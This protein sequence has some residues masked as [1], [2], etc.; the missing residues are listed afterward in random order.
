MAFELLSEP[1]RRYVKDKRWE[2]LRPIQAAAIEKIMKSDSN[3]ILASRTA[4]GKTEA[5]FLPILSK[6]SPRSESVQVLYIS[7]LIALIND[8]FIR[9]EDLCSY[10]DIKVTKWHGEAN[11]TAKEHLI[12]EPNGVVLITPESLEAMLVNKSQY[13]SIL[14]NDLKYIVID[15]IHSFIG[16]DRG[17][18]LKSILHRIQKS[19]KVTPAIVGLSATLGDFEEA[20]RM[21]GRPDATVVLRDRTAKSM[22]TSFRYFESGANQLSLELLKDLYKETYNSK[23]LVFP[24]SRGRAEEVAVKLKRIAEKVN[25]HTCY[26]SHHSSVDRELR[27]W[28]EHFAKTNTYHPFVISCTSTLELGIDIGSVEKVVQIDATH[29]IASLIQRVGRSGRKDGQAS[30]LLL[31]ATGKWSL[32]QSLACWELYKQEFIEPPFVALKPFDLFAHQ[33]LAVVKQYSGLPISILKTELEQNFAFKDIKYE[34][35]DDILSHLIETDMLEQLGKEV[36]IGLEGERIVNSRDFYSVFATEIHFKVLHDGKSI[37]DL[38]SSSPIMIEDNILL[39]AKIWK[40]VNMDFRSRKIFVKPT[41]DGKP[42]IFGGEP[43]NT[44]PLVRQ[45]MLELL[46][47]SSI[48]PELDEQCCAIL[49]DMRQVFKDI[50]I[51]SL[52]DDRPLFVGENSYKFYTFQGSKIFDTL[53]FILSAAG[54]EFRNQDASA[55]IEIDKEQ[56]FE[57]SAPK[58]LAVFQDL[59]Q[60]LAFRIDTNPAILSFAKWAILIPKDKQI[61]L[62]KSRRYDFDGALKFINSVRWMYA[63]TD[64]VDMQTLL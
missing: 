44:H 1:I 61:E 46:M 3:V 20:K 42:P 48:H 51:E 16:T 14:F 52:E 7:P 45:K 15:E 4:S 54:L 35:F 53:K 17:I 9:V 2:S 28:I 24:N 64:D 41:N 60:H 8:Q 22:V 5:A 26:Y 39:A 19:A 30:S 57:W 31:Y 37:G 11:R 50:S 33:L 13:V 18:Q 63:N 27:E 38:P 62:L 36:I 59:D 29:S 32:L 25:G 6:I 12:K 56:G 10:L 40:V 55:S 58:L 47:T 21:T 34:E 49:D 43:G 23:V